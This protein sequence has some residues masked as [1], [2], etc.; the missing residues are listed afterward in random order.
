MSSALIGPIL[1][2]LIH[3]IAI[4]PMQ[5]DTVK[6]R[7]QR[8]ARRLAEIIDDGCDLM[9]LE[10]AWRLEIQFSAGPSKLTR[11]G[12]CR[13]GHRKVTVANTHVSAP[14]AMPQLKNHSPT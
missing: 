7:R 8:V 3:Q 10:R 4:T 11:R 9:K 12:Q 5:F 14:T 13:R 6:P 2:E 1:Q